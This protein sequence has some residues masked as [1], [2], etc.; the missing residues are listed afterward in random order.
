MRSFC[1]PDEEN[2]VTLTQKKRICSFLILKNTVLQRRHY[3]M[4]AKAKK[5]PVKK[6]MKKK[7]T[8]KPK[9]KKV[10]KKKPAKK[11]KKR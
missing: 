10:A 1:W 7:A 11:A 6:V 2:K 9:A 8:K 3:L 5:K 4:K